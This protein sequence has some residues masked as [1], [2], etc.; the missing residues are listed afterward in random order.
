MCSQGW[1]LRL[2]G[3][4]LRRSPEATETAGRLRDREKPASTLGAHGTEMT[5]I[6]TTLF[7]VLF[8]GK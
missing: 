3:L 6:I 1:E 5:G 4:E 7:F 8:T 2:D